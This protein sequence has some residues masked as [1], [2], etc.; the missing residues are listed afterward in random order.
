MEDNE[1]DDN[2]DNDN[3]HEAENQV[4]EVF[5]EMVAAA[6]AE[7]LDATEETEMPSS[8][9]ASVDGGQAPAEVEG[10]HAPAEGEGRDAPHPNQEQGGPLSHVHCIP[11]K[12]FQVILCSVVGKHIELSA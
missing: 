10:G 5:N 4:D 2:D 11:L 1:H 9:A 8:G 12:S 7:N 3:E 6:A